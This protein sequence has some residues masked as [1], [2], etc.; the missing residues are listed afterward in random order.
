ME[1][2]NLSNNY[3]VIVRNKFKESMGRVMAPKLGNDK[4]PAN[5]PVIFQEIAAGFKGVK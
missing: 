2:S 3:D 1:A 5:Y 4:L